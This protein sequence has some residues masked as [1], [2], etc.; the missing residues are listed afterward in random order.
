[1]VYI[2][3]TFA[4]KQSA[5]QP[6]ASRSEKD[7]DVKKATAQPATLN[8]VAETALHNQSE[9]QKSSPPEPIAFSVDWLGETSYIFSKLL[10]F[11]LE[12]HRE[13]QQLNWHGEPIDKPVAEALLRQIK[14]TSKPEC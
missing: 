8:P 10:T 1:M 12:V 7:T 13:G 9:E 4:T 3:R 5:A 14:R 11:S 2:E 6:L